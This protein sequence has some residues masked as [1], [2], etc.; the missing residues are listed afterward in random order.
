M[1]SS[2]EILKEKYQFVN[3]A[4]V[5]SATF[6]MNRQA[7]LMSTAQQQINEICNIAE[8]KRI[9]TFYFLQD[10]HELKIYNLHEYLKFYL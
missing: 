4:T 3:S 10:M 1:L 9:P 7:K 8:Q 5:N 2:S 6:S